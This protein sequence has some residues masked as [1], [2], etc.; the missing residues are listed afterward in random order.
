[1]FNKYL[2]K[3]IAEKKSRFILVI[4][5][6]AIISALVYILLS[7]NKVVESDALESLTAQY[8]KTDII[9]KSSDNENGYFITESI[10][11]DNIKESVS[12]CWVNGEYTKKNTTYDVD[13][14][15][16][17]KSDR[18]NIISYKELSNKDVGEHGI[19]ISKFTSDKYD[20][21]LGDKVSFKIYDTKYDFTVSSIADNRGLLYDETS[22]I[23][24]LIDKS[25]LKDLLNLKND[26]N[27]IYIELNS[28]ED[29]QETI[30]ELENEY[31][32]IDFTEVDTSLVADSLN[33]NMTIP[34]LI[35]LV[36]ACIMSILIIYTTTNVVVLERMPV[37][38]T[39]LS[40]G[41]SQKK[42]IASLL[43]ETVIQGI[44]GGFI[45]FV[46]GMYSTDIIVSGIPSNILHWLGNP[47]VYIVNGIISLL[48]GIVLSF[49]SVLASVTK[50]KSFTIKE[51][52]LN[53]TSKAGK[54]IS[55]R[56]KIIKV[57]IPIVLLILAILF[58][59]IV[60]SI[61]VISAF[62]IILV[63][64]LEDILRF[65]SEK[66]INKIKYKMPLLYVALKNVCSLKMLI[67]NMKLIIIT[68]ALITMIGTISASVISGFSKLLTDFHSD[69]SIVLEG[70]KQDVYDYLE[71]D[72][73]ISDYYYFHDLE[74]LEV[75]GS[76]YKIASVQ[77][78]ESNKYS[79]FNTYF[80]YIGGVKILKTLNGDERNI[81]LSQT[82]LTKYN[83]K[84]GD[85]I[86]LKSKNGEKF[87]YKI[88][89]IVNAKLSYVGS[90][91][92]ISDE[93]AKKDFNI[94]YPN[95]ICI[96]LKD[97]VD[98]DEYYDKLSKS[99]ISKD[100]DSI[101]L[102]YVKNQKD[103]KMTESFLSII[104]SVSLITIILAILGILNNNLI[105]FI[106]R[107]K[108]LATLDSIG[109]S[110][111]QRKIILFL[112]SIFMAIICILVSSI[113]YYVVISNIQGILTYIGVYMQLDYDIIK[114][115]QYSL[116]VLLELLI[117]GGVIVK[118]VSKLSIIEE[119]KYE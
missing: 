38:G 79:K 106:Q 19:T 102:D 87:D 33:L 27:V 29:K 61:C 7:T 76:N 82:L 40:I 21:K 119:L 58:Q 17:N 11:N 103:L 107:R 10:E 18:G 98:I 78:V 55:L 105:C 32:K 31:E 6:I 2:L 113:L 91:A 72:K 8:G 85:I 39:F 36:V 75:V 62:I 92:L 45:G 81:I 93:S 101:S 54:T 24:I 74:N 1:M 23:K 63:I 108:T 49:F 104:N 70:E 46:F 3:N 89:G 67:N 84:V 9:A 47:N 13:L 57:I 66:C 86:T 111:K 14:I 65:F 115:L 35:V 51:I 110:I 83:K 114:F 109:F 100:I 37:I 94:N 59:G 15:G 53:I 16:I 56:K 50:I 41:M 52:I 88:S 28:N 60:R 5:S 77:G 96:K 30:E 43:G 48:F 112:E 22:S 69:V 116:L 42:I 118:K 95:V 90:V 117:S 73:E 26:N 44:I 20:L 64:Y 99:N 68:L 12:L 71:N 80:D 34:L 25:E 4:L 97:G